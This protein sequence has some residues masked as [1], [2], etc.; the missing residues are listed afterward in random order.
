M[1]DRIQ[2]SNRRKKL[3]VLPEF[4][5]RMIRQAA[6]WPLATLVIA[7]TL[8][9]VAWRLVLQ[10]VATTSTVIESL[11]LLL[12]AFA[13]LIGSAVFVI[14]YQAMLFSNRVAG[15]V[16]RIHKA[17]EAVRA[18]NLD[19]RI[20]L[21]EKDLLLETADEFNATIDVL[22]KR[23][24]AAERRVAASPNVEAA[25]SLLEGAATSTL[26]TRG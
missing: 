13:L 18:G 17:L 6:F 23:V 3:I 19:V 4:Q 26:G 16:Y 8:V 12:G 25:P 2:T 10:E 20:K 22:A 21:R 24:A 15:P 11:A 1:A 9:G 5:R 14:L 7:S